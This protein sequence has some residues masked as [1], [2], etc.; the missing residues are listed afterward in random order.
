MVSIKKVA[1]D[2]KSN[3]KYDAILDYV[4]KALNTNKPTLE[5]I[6]QLV[7][8]DPYYI[9]E[10]KDLNRWGELSSIHI[11]PLNIKDNED[12]HSKEIKEKINSQLDYLINGEEYEIP[13]KRLIYMAWTGFI[14][15]PS[16]YV[17]DNMVRVSTDLYTTNENG[18]YFSFIIV[19][20]ASIWGYIKVSKNHKNQHTKYINT[21]KE[22]R[23]YVKLGLENKYFTYE[24]VYK[25]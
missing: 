16:I 9:K 5:E 22:V 10:Y 6:E 25:D 1:K 12:N 8:D 17:I 23:G 11:K 20:I 18:V 2:I 7:K 4:K 13:S 3:G 19:L 24:E 15:L 14:A 21:Q